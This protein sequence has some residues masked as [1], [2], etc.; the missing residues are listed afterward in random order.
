MEERCPDLAAAIPAL[1]AVA[2]HTVHVLST[3]AKS[4]S[5][6]GQPHRAFAALRAPGYSAY[7]IG[8][9]LAMMAD[10]IEHVISYWMVFQKFQSS[11]LGGFAVLS[12]WL[13]FLLFSVA[14]GALADRFDPRRIIQA[15]MVLFMLCSLA[16]GVLFMTDT[17]EIWHAA[18]IFTAH[19]F[20]GVLWS[21]AS[22]MLIH[23]IVGR[24]DL[25]SAVRLLSMSRVLGLLGG[26]AVGGVMLLALGPSTAVFVNVAIYLPLIVWLWR[27]PFGPRF[28]KEPQA[29]AR[30]AGGLA[31]IVATAREIAGNR[32]VVSMTLLA[33]ASSFVVGNAYQ[34]QM[35]EFAADLGHADADFLYSMLLAA[36]AAGALTAGIVLE[37]FGVL[38]ARPKIAFVLVMLWCFCIGGFAVSN[39]YVLSLALLFAAGFLNLAYG[40]MSQ[41][42]VQMHAPD[43]IR[44]RV[45]GLYGTSMSGMR[46]FS[47]ITVGMGGSL[48]GV[49]WSLA[50]SAAALFVVTL[51]LVGYDMRTRT[52]EA[53]E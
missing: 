15:G 30:E 7:L 52:A 26:P 29:T 31:G 38:R 53:A 28:R 14:S 35:P 11:A 51:G 19:G 42:L 20:A 5:P 39:V 12:H 43:R 2:R 6:S 24:S 49:H 32:I 33:G 3:N 37:M 34:A 48:V 4:Q 10:N 41:T 8:T 36:N 44:G 25:H 40:A 46:A 21:P 45:L 22:Q 27:A 47:G 13:P 23:D 9:A 50:L 18:V 1:H 16:W 17:L